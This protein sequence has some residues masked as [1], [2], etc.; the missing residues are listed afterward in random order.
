MKK[1]LINLKEIN[2]TNHLIT[3]TRFMSI[4]EEIQRE[5]KECKK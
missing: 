3:F 1:K 5:S 4:I 2:L